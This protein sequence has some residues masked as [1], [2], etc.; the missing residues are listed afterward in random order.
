MSHCALHRNALLSAGRGKVHRAPLRQLWFLTLHYT[1]ALLKLRIHC[2]RK[3]LHRAA[4]VPLNLL[5]QRDCTGTFQGGQKDLKCEQTQ[6]LDLCLPFREKSHVR[7]FPAT[8]FNPQVILCSSKQCLKEGRE[9]LLPSLLSHLPGKGGEQLFPLLCR[10]PL[11]SYLPTAVQRSE[12]SRPLSRAKMPTDPPCVWC[13]GSMSS[14]CLGR[15]AG[16]TTL[17]S[18][19]ASQPTFCMATCAH[20]LES[21]GV[22]MKHP[23]V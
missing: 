6:T 11:T 10:Q 14:H 18:T 5:W 12:P 7:L 9:W 20:Q 13:L 3:V 4:Y 23:A 19:S 17:L 1:D 2:V 15:R 16:S 8:D 21:K 22:L